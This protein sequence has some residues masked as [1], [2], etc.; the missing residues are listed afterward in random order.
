MQNDAASHTDEARPDGLTEAEAA[1]QRTLKAIV[2][3]LGILI[4]LAFA[5]VV[6]GMAY[7]A[8]QIGKPLAGSSPTAGAKGA[9]QPTPTLLSPPLAADVKLSLPQGSAIKSATLSGTRLVVHHDGPAGTGIVILD[10]A[11]GQI[12]SRVTIETAPGR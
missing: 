2:I 9:G 12:V 6:A 10:L 3:G 11:T 4:L 5:G 1:K 7:R 8:S